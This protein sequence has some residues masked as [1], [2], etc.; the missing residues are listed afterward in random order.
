MVL[1]GNKSDLEDQ[2][3]IDSARAANFALEKG[4]TFMETSCEKNIKVADAFTVLIENT[5]I[6]MKKEEERDEDKLKISNKGNEK[7]N[8]KKKGFRCWPF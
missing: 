1:L 3:K 2:R 7:K 4:Y 6:R 8:K 5:N